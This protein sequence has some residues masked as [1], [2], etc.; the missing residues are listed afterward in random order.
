MAI[1]YAAPAATPGP[2]V[3]DCCAG[4]RGGP[5]DEEALQVPVVSQEGVALQVRVARLVR[6]VRLDRTAAAPEAQGREDPPEEDREAAQ[7][8]RSRRAAVVN[9]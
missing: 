5:Q 6:T 9:A 7:S 3:V 8:S 1:R 2:A 4:G